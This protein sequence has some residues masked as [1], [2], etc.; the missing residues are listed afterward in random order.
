MGVGVGAGGVW[1]R[2]V[3]CAARRP[4]RL[5]HGLSVLFSYL[6]LSGARS[7]TRVAPRWRLAKPRGEYLVNIDL[8][9]ETAQKRVT[10]GWQIHGTKVNAQIML[11]L[12]K[13]PALPRWLLLSTTQVHFYYYFN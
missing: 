6:I 5:V 3:V 7:G 9:R 11:H 4:V 12:N 1:R 13:F 8:G 10:A 2:V